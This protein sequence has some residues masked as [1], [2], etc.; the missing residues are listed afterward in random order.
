MQMKIEVVTRT[1]RTLTL[2]QWMQMAIKGQKISAIR[3]LRENSE[4]YT[5]Y[6]PYA[7]PRERYMSLVHAKKIVEHFMEHISDRNIG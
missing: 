1:E 5:K 7:S 3:E 6:A 2:P 4:L